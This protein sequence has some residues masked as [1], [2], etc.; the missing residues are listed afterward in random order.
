MTHF[1]D[2][3][4]EIGEGDGG[5]L[6]ALEGGFGDVLLDA[7]GGKERAGDGVDGPVARIEDVEMA[8]GRGGRR[9]RGNQEEPEGGDRER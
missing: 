4:L 3:A 8:R 6:E 1:G 2:E 9:E 7:G 5:D